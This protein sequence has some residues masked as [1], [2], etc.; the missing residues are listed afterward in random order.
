MGFMGLS[1]WN[2]SD[3]A[4]DFV[5]AFK[6]T[7]PDEKQM[8]GCI[9]QEFKNGANTYNTPGFINVALMVEDGILKVSK[10]NRSKFVKI[11]KVCSKML[12]DASKVKSQFTNDF[13]RMR[14]S[15]DAWCQKK[16]RRNIMGGPVN[17][18]FRDEKG[19]VD[20][21]QIWTGGMKHIQM[22]PEVVELHISPM[23]YC[24]EWYDKDSILN[25]SKGIYPDGYG[26]LVI[27]YMKNEMYT[28]QGYCDIG[29]SFSM[30]IQPSNLS[31][32][33]EE[34]ATIKHHIGIGRVDKI[35]IGYGTKRKNLI[36]AKK[37][38]IT[39]KSAMDFVG[40]ELAFFTF[41]TSP[42]KVKKWSETKQGY[43]ALKKH[44]IKAGFKVNEVKWTKFVT[45][46]YD[47]Y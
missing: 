9:K 19:K 33:E 46:T 11:L 26:L 30:L 29:G 10:E 4:A 31:G 42:L 16:I 2:D 12:D 45:E 23:H 15:V 35:S 13:I 1:H 37:N 27:D 39:I 36:N 3:N 18:V 24:D 32:F 8:L 41:N 14:A 44:M 22:S 7:I 21:R 43:N 25:T 40:T 20:F 38:P 28:I 6:K 17:F 34:I 47:E 5:S